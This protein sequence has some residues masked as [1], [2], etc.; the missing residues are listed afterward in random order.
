VESAG[1]GDTPPFV[2]AGVNGLF[3][4]ICIFASAKIVQTK[5]LGV[6]IVQT[7]DLRV[8]GECREQNSP[9][10]GELWSLFLGLSSNSIIGFWSGWEC[11]L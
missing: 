10:A 2:A 8:Q 7:K 11:N 4:G 9:T 5:G 6:K 3:C 1:G